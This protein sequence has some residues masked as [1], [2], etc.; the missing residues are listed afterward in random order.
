MKRISVKTKILILIITLSVV[1]LGLFAWL[2]FN[3][4]KKDKLAFI[5]DYL[6]N[7]IHSKSQYLATT[8]DNYKLFLNTIISGM[9]FN[10]SSLSASQMSL[11]ENNANIQGIYF[12]Q[13][14]AGSSKENK[15]YESSLVEEVLSFQEMHSKQMGLSLIDGKKGLFL[16]K[17]PVDR[18][19][20]FAAIIFKQMELSNLFKST[21]GRMGFVL[22]LHGHTADPSSADIKANIERL[23]RPFGLF[24]HTIN[25]K[26]YF[27]SF[28]KIPFQ[29]LIVVNLIEESKVMLIQDMFLKQALLFLLLMASVSLLIG[30][31]AASWLTG[32]LDQ[33]TAAAKS[34]EAEDFDHK[35]EVKSED[36][37]GILGA[38]FNSMGEKV[39]YLLVE[40]RRYNTQLE[41]MVEERTKELQKLTDIQNAML[42]S[43]GQGFVT[44]DKEYK[45]NSVY[46]KA[47]VDM[48]EVTPSEVT[49][50]EIL[51]IKEE[52]AQSF[53]DLYAMA[54]EN[55]LDFDDVSKLNPELRSNSKNQKIFLSYAPIRNGE[56][57]NLDYV[58]VIGT[59]KT[60]ELESLEKFKKEWAFSQMITKMASNRFSL[61]KVISESLS[62]LKQAV[63]AVEQNKQYAVREVQRLVH[64]V[65][66]SFSYF[67]IDEVT[68]LAHDFETFLTPY[69]DNQETPDELKLSMLEKIM[70]IQVAIE[71]YIDHFDNILQYKDANSSRLIAI[72]DL[73]QFSHKLR[74]T[75]PAL[76]MDFKNQFYRTKIEPFFQMYPTIVKDLGIKLNKEVRFVLEGGQLDLPEG[77]WGEMFQQFI[78]VVRNSMDHGIETP[79]EREASGKSSMGEIRFK[80]EVSGEMLR[81][82]LSDDGRGLDWTKIAKKDPTVTSEQDAINRIKD[83]GISSKDEVSDISGR[84]V[85]VSA[86]FSVAKS[87]DVKA[88]L[89]NNLGH[90]MKIIIEIPLENKN[91]KGFLKS[92]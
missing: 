15:L 87:W 18:K 10:A 76:Y 63:Q 23:S 89:V 85:G 74:S 77:N 67:Y 27:V 68:A 66:G 6:A 46:S 56:T 36:E 19:N 41:A 26:E 8:T 1:S 81:V 20:A 60:A 84:G 78:H 39:K 7:E 42:N 83:G 40:L 34:F 21:E 70:G 91:L 51:G 4:Y 72:K 31:L 48:F 13:G 3:S 52:E 16:L 29:N 88:E 25:E 35:I 17:Q 38:A 28:S 9:N 30:T 57:G 59:D 12:Y 45:I 54:F 22:G 90:G 11:L 71:C 43:L 55:M 14:E 69:Y 64:T 33:L 58:M 79:A 50:T 80:F 37:I 75:H 62:M 47:A 82:T 24:K 86:V 61:I 2:T 92:A 32:H 53:K 44:I 65:K 73:D 49:P 5:Y